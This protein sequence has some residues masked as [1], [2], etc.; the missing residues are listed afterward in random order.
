MPV[1]ASQEHFFTQIQVEP[2]SSGA[3]RKEQGE[4]FLESAARAF[5]DGG[6]QV[7]PRV[8]ITPLPPEEAIVEKRLQDLTDELAQEFGVS[9]YSLYRWSRQYYERGEA[10]LVLKW[11]LSPESGAKITE[12]HGTFPVR[13]SMMK[14]LDDYASGHPQWST[15]QELLSNTRPEPGLKSWDRVRWILGDVGTQIFRY[16]F[17]PDRIPTTLELMD[18]TAVELHEF[19]D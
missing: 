17:T 16:Y 6:L 19:N 5:R 13:E 14:Y 7:T 15:A 3:R 2:G 4:A 18:E 1:A 8:V 9:E 12:A 10:G 11:L